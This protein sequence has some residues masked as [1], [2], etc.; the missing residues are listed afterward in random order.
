MIKK[1]IIS[2]GFLGGRRGWQSSP[3]PRFWIRLNT[4]LN[5]AGKVGSKWGNNAAVLGES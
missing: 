2:G 4:V 3:S 5:G 1:G